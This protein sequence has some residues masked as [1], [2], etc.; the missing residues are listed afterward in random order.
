MRI[1][2]TRRILLRNKKCPGQDGCGMMAPAD[3][4]N[5]GTGD[6]GTGYRAVQAGA[7]GTSRMNRI[8]IDLEMNGIPEECKK[9]R[10]ICSTE[11]IEIG[12]V[13]L[14]ES[15]RELRSFRR[16]VR[17][18]YSSEIFPV[19]GELTGIRTEMVIHEKT[20]RQVL[21]DFLSWCGR[22]YLIYSWSACDL[23]QLRHEV[24]LKQIRISPGLRYMFSHWRDFQK[25]FSGFFNVHRGLSL[26]KA[27][28]VS[29][30]RYAGQPHDGLAD[31]R[32]TAQLYLKT[33]SR[34]ARRGMRQAVIEICQ[35]TKT[36]QERYLPA[37]TQ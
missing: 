29:G 15:G 25:E 37:S 22:D 35:E 20:F 10:R 14:D 24:Q 19:I 9:E 12:A 21:P 28:A 1:L 34:S 27:V 31:A 6:Q 3:T 17:P 18:E 30:I 2:R 4:G 11:V 23:W 33:R 13:M 7:E 16:Y 32:T 5:R 8:F 26:G 36:G